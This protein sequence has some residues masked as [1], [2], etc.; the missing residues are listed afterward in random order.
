MDKVEKIKREHVDVGRWIGVKNNELVKR[1]ASPLHPSTIVPSDIK[2]QFL[3]VIGG[4]I[5][6]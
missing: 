3:I 1:E 5:N 2:W 6:G 4:Y